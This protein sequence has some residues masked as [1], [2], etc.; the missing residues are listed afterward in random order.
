MSLFGG[1]LKL[2]SAYSSCLLFTINYKIWC[3]NDSYSFWNGSGRW[4]QL[5]VTT[6]L[7]HNPSGRH[8]PETH[9]FVQPLLW[10]ITQDTLKEGG[11]TVFSGILWAEF[12]TAGD[13]DPQNRSLPSCNSS[14]L[15]RFQSKRDLVSKRI[16]LSNVNVYIRL[17]RVSKC[18]QT[19][20]SAREW[21][22]KHFKR[23][24]CKVDSP[25]CLEGFLH[26]W[27]DPPDQVC[28]ICTPLHFSSGRRLEN[29]ITPLGLN[30]FG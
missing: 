25:S 19:L 26:C 17:N 3:E 22:N 14:P 20:T 29:T 5:A 9:L 11:R 21:K 1:E 12:V 8:R 7:Q 23:T 18:C 13:L 4:A 24:C 10:P 27:G 15:L 30:L 6:C 28:A 2:W 16:K